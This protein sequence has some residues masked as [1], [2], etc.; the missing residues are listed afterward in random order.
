MQ[1][2]FA[3]CVAIRLAPDGKCTVASAGQTA[4]FLNGLEVDIPGAIPLGI[5]PSVSYE[6]ATLQLNADDHLVLYTDGLLEARNS[7]GELYSFDRLQA[8]FASRPTAE[9]ATKAAV[10]FGQDDD[11]TVLTLVRT[12]S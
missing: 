1:G 9:E 2:G 10:S 5:M 11:I 3:T 8:L 4:P 7:A 12:L 6:E